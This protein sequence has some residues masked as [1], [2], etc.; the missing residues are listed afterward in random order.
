M[1]ASLSG[2]GCTAIHSR[3][4]VEVRREGLKESSHSPGVSKRQER[5]DVHQTFTNAKIRLLVIG[6]ERGG[7]G[8]GKRG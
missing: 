5:N 3:F 7:G 1:S 6:K 8:G 4:E 2:T